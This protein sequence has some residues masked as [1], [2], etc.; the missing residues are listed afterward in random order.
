L[1][2]TGQNKEKTAMNVP[3]LLPNDLAKATLLEIMEN[4][5][6]HPIKSAEGFRNAALDGLFAFSPMLDVREERFVNFAINVVQEA[7]RE[8]RMIDFGFLPNDLL[9]ETSSRTRDAFEAGELQHPYESWVGVSRWEGGMCG[10]FIAP[11]TNDDKATIVIEIY[12]VA[13][14]GLPPAV[15]INDVCSVKVGA[16]GTYIHPAPMISEMFNRQ[17]EL[18]RRAANML[19]P[20]VALLRL[21]SDASVPVVDVPAPDKLNKHRVKHDKSPIPPHTRVETRDYVSLF[22]THQN[23]GSQKGGQKGH[24]SSPV[25]HWR[26]SHQRHLT[27]GRVVPVRSTKVNWR[28]NETLHRLFSRVRK[29]HDHGHDQKSE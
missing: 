3:G 16:D 7:I 19:D 26:R 21:L 5:Q 10:Y 4:F 23:R 27:S 9:M 8:G 28:D 24:H 12:G 29:D 15:I 17:P 18:D 6:T 1:A 14:P 2:E 13:V 20:L 22:Q 25:P 11:E